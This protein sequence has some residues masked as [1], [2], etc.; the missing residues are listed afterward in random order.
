[1][2]TL[3]EKEILTKRLLGL[4]VEECNGL[5]GKFMGFNIVFDIVSKK[6]CIASEKII[7]SGVE[8]RQ[9]YSE[10]PNY[11][12]NWADLMPVVKKIWKLGHDFYIHRDYCGIT[13]AGDEEIGEHD[14]G[15]KHGDDPI[16]SIWLAVVQ[17]VQWYNIN[18]KESA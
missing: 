14:I 10:I 3:E 9:G 4:T 15:H 1:M 7:I 16:Y 5:V 6:L 11:N 18:K 13:I 2:N 8:V 12:S 17:F